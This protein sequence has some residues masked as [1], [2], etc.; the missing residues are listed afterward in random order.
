MKTLAL[1]AEGTGLEQ[2][3]KN[4]GKATVSRVRGTKTTRNVEV[5][6]DVASS[7]A[8]Q[9][10]IALW[11]TLTIASQNRVYELAQSEHQQRNI[12]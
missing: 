6:K 8:L 4:T 10:L 9:E 11:P 7:I 5:P 12:A 2:P 1:G 3:A